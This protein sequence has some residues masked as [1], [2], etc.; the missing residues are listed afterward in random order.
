MCLAIIKNGSSS[1]ELVT[2]EERFLFD[3]GSETI[4]VDEHEAGEEGFEVSLSVEEPIEETFVRRRECLELALSEFGDVDW[5]VNLGLEE[6]HGLG[7]G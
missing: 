7:V 4:A 5:T 6:T 1:Q 3:D 2:I